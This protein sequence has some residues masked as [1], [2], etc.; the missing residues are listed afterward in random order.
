MDVDLIA[1]STARA[2][3]FSTPLLWAAL[4]EIFAERA[5]VVNLGVEGMMI[6]GAVTGFIVGQTTGDPWLGLLAAAGA[7]ALA[8]LLHAFISITLQANQYVSGLALTIFGLGLSGFLGR[9]W[10]GRPLLEPMSFFSVPVLSD[11]PFLG[12]AFFTGQYVLTYLGLAAAV[13]LWAFL[14]HTK[15]GLILRTVGES[16]AAADVAGVSVPRV[17]YLAVAFGGFCA[18]IGGGY[19]SLAYRPSWGEGMTNG[20]GWIALAL[21]IFALWDP[22][23]AV[24]AAFLFGL[25]FTLSFSLQGVFPPSLL[26]MMPYLFTIAALTVIALRQGGRAFGAPDAL[27]IPYRRGER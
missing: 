3:A 23:R 14:Y 27:G 19:L 9:T 2:L 12:A 13:V 5:G 21:A 4:G 16:P 6:L 11:L 1:N 7:G 22:L 17:R 24:G 10:V 20:M 26:T 25:F 8:A 15:W 18:G